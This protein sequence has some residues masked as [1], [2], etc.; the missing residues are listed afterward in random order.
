[1]S[2]PNEILQQIFEMVIQSGSKVTVD[3]RTPLEYDPAWVFGLRMV[4]RKLS[5]RADINKLIYQSCVVASDKKFIWV[6]LMARFKEI[7]AGGE[8]VDKARSARILLAE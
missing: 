3:I 8:K 6:T 2:L 4:S 7:W 1:M 5:K